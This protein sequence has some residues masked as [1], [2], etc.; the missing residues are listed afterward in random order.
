MFLVDTEEGRIVDDEEIKEDGAPQPY[1]SGSREPVEPRELPGRPRAAARRADLLERQ[2]V[3]G[4]TL[5]DLRILLAPMA[6][7]GRSRSARWATTRR[8]RCCPTSRSCSSTTSSSSS[9]R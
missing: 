8:W 2:Q 1:A 5:E 4:Y 7:N 9:R 6:T 3:F